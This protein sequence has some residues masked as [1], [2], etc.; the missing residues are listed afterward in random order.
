[1][2]NLMFNVYED[3]NLE[4]LKKLTLNR[5]D[6]AIL[7]CGVEIAVSLAAISLYDLRR[8]ILVPIVNIGLASLSLIGLCGAL[9]LELRQIQIHGAVTTGLIIACLLNFLAEALLTRTGF[10]S[11]AMPSWVVLTVF[12]IPYSLNLVCSIISLLLGDAFAKFL[13]LEEQKSDLAPTELIEQ[14]AQEYRGSDIVAFAWKGART[15]FSRL[16]ATE[17]CVSIVGTV[18]SLHASARFAGKISTLSC[19][20]LIPDEALSW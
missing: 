8:S 19:G 1:M 13:A 14:Q 3:Q 12:F 7:S 9:K 18:S 6:S 2:H 5:R 15:L 16:V 10:G 17:S 11:A 4:R 20:S